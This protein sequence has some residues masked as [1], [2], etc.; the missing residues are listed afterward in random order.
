M[1]GRASGVGYV[2]DWLTGQRGGEHVLQAMARLAPKA[3][4]YT[5][6]H[7]PGSVSPEIESHR[8]VTSFLQGAPLLEQRYR[9]YLPLF[10][11]AMRSLDATAHPLL[12][13]SSHCVAKGI[14]RAPNAAHVCYCHT[15]M[16]YAWD[17][18]RAYFPPPAG[19]VGWLRE[20]IL[21]RLQA[22]DVATANRVDL[23]LANSHFVAA[24]IRRYYG[25][26]SQ[27]LPPPV[28]IA[29]FRPTGEAR[30]RFVLVVAALAPYKKV[31]VAI[32]ACRR[33][34]VPL[35]IVGDGPER[36]R[37]ERA[38]DSS[39][40]FA[41]STQRRA[42]I[43]RRALKISASRRSRRWPAAPPFSRSRR[44]GFS[45]SSRAAARGFWSTMRASKRSPP[46]L[47]K[48][49]RC[50]SIRWTFEAGRRTFPP[51]GSRSV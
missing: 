13:S 26:S 22:W 4:I 35:V 43:F 7:F 20:R 45:T 42:A 29:Y 50:S 18:R 23:F 36:A 44:G 15:P 51:S 25:R 47:T 2:H 39:V 40:R 3:P 19:P 28:D 37:L 5:L 21:D 46:R 34:G 12:V 33:A 11:A 16:R 41:G 1:T 9:H 30:E 17:Q 27:V 32:E 48:S 49:Y 31:D 14:R 10:P 24:R 8:I 38:A 6:F